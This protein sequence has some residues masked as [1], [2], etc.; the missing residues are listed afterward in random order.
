MKTLTAIGWIIF[1]KESILSLWKYNISKP[2]AAKEKFDHLNGNT[3][4]GE[5]R[6]NTAPCSFVLGFP[7]LSIKNDIE[8]FPDFSRF[9]D[10]FPAWEEGMFRL[11]KCPGLPESLV[12][13]LVS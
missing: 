5:R 3:S 1:C 13:V 12:H 10:I 7:N 8:S 6:T 2:L 9:T 11:L 4:K